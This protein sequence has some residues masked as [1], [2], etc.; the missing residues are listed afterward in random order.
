M[1]LFLYSKLRPE[2]NLNDMNNMNKKLLEMIE[3]SKVKVGYIAS[4][5]D[6]DRIFFNKTKEYYNDL[7]ISSIVYFDLESEYQ[8]KHEEK[9][10][11][12]DI[13]HLS[14]GNT[15]SFLNNLKNKQLLPKLKQFALEGGILVGVSAGA[16]ILCKDIS[17]SKFGDKN[18]TDLVDLTALGLVDFKIIPHWNN[19]NDKLDDIKTFSRE[20]NSLVYLL[21]DGN[22][23]VVDGNELYFYGNIKKIYQGLM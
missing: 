3:I 9:L 7:G 18:Y 5:N 6:P 13:V 4:Q 8:L 19:K 16:H 14:S 17:A 10:F 12:C 21:D 23:I 22:G 11:E 1:R 2:I 15:Y 20:L